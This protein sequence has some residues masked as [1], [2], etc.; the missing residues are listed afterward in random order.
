MGLRE[1]VNIQGLSPPGVIHPNKKEIRQKFQESCM[2]EQRAL[3]P[4]QTKKGILQ[5]VK[6]RK[7]SL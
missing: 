2:D 1:L 7:G 5:K 3:G 4:T 6:A